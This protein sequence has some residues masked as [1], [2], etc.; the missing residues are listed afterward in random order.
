MINVF[1]VEGG[2]CCKYLPFHC[3]LQMVFRKDMFD[4]AGGRKVLKSQ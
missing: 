4:H 2:F 1:F 3:A